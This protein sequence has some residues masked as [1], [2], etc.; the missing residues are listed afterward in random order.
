MQVILHFVST[1]VSSSMSNA[2]SLA[3]DKDQTLTK[4]SFDDVTKSRVVLSSSSELEKKKIFA[5]TFLGSWALKF[6]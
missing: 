1:W 5:E 6:F 3:L 2:P 4:P